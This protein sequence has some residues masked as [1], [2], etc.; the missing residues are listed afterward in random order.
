MVC[1]HGR[2]SL[3][4]LPQTVMV[5]MTYGRFLREQ[6]GQIPLLNGDL[7]GRSIVLTGATGGLGLEAAVHLAAMRPRNL[8]LTYRSLE[9]P[10]P[11]FQAFR[12]GLSQTIVTFVPRFNVF[13]IREKH[14]KHRP[15]LLL[16]TYRSLE[17]PQP[18]FQ[19]FRTGLSQTI[20][21]FVPRFNVFR[22]REK[23]GKHRPQLQY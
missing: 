4:F 12:T 13:R 15:Q 3:C 9:K 18:A 14:G 2:F 5:Q 19:A 6:W 11:A 21:T 20:V 1:I 16:L 7:S 8:L 17:K 23:H 10:Q 22:I